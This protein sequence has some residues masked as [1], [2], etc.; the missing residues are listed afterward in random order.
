[1]LFFGKMNVLFQIHPAIQGLH[2]FVEAHGH[3]PEPWNEAH[4]LEL[5]KLVAQVKA[6]DKV[7]S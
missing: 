2:K 3:K 6:D 7:W 5:I 4:A 1:M